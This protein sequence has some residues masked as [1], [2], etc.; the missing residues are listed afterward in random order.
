MKIL[1]LYGFDFKFDLQEL[2]FL[3]IPKPLKYF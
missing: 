3:F 2:Q 1:E